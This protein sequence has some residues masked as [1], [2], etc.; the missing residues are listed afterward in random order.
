MAQSLHERIAQQQRIN[1][2]LHAA[3]DT[4]VAKDYL[5]TVV[6]AYSAFANR[7]AQG[8]LTA[9]RRCARAG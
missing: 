4:K 2:E 8:D 6:S 5:D 1:E 7:V 3:N 9:A